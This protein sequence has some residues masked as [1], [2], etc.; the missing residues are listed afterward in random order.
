MSAP[1]LTRPRCLRS[2]SVLCSIMVASATIAGGEGRA[3]SAQDSPNILWFVV[4]D[5]SAHFS[6]YGEKA[7]E[8]PHVDRLA[9]EGTRFT[10][11]YTTAPVCSPSRSAMITGCYQTRIGA[12]HHR[13]GRGSVPIHLPREI[14][15]VPVLFQKAGYYTC[16][17]SGIAETETSN[18]KRQGLGKTDYN[19]QWDESA[20]D[21][22]D[23]SGRTP[24]QP[25]FAQVQIHGGKMRGEKTVQRAGLAKQANEETGCATDR[26]SVSLPPYYPADDEILDDWTAYLDAVRLTDAHVG[27]VLARLE[28]EQLLENTFIIFMTD[29]GISHARGK[30]FLYDEGTHIPLIVRGPNVP[31][32]AVRADLVEHIDMAASS[33]AAADIKIPSWMQ[34]RDFFASDGVPREA[35]FAARD[36]CDETVDRIRSVRTDQWLFIRNEHPARPM[37]QPNAYKDGKSI[38]QRLRSL[39]ASGSLSPL[40]EKILFAPQRSKEE[41]YDLKTD[42]FQ[43]ENVASDPKNAEVVQEMRQRLSAWMA[44]CG[45][46]QPESPSQYASDMEVYLQSQK[47]E[48]REVIENNIQLN[49]K[50]RAEGF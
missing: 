3:N 28:N 2:W 18:Q 41:L 23:W 5:M 4:E 34:G 38:L 13:S 16:N 9:R 39:H 42:P 40:Q 8:T 1:V 49:T 11:A 27:R 33:L 21:A 29:H 31:R 22:S 20:Y 43:L 32:G 45:D 25:F 10:R 48:R 50:W 19:F 47:G 46:D 35:V 24:G 6:C 12:Q 44:S 30:Q 15:P 7:V 26:S 37:L 36:R 14:V 17:G